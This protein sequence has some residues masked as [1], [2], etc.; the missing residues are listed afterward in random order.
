M[1]WGRGAKGWLWLVLIVNGL[2]CLGIFPL[3]SV[4]PMI[5]V[6]TLISEVILIFGVVLLLFSK[7]KIG[8]YLL[9]A[10]AVLTMIFNIMSG[11]GIIRAVASV[12]L[13]PTITYLVIRDQ[14]NELA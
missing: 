1:E 6:F 4:W 11:V 2:S 13:M 12:V 8:F 7:K 9:C 14:W 3:F 5:A 10:C